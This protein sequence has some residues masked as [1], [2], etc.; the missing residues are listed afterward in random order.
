MAN[1]AESEY[2]DRRD[3]KLR[4]LL[5]LMDSPYDFFRLSQ[6]ETDALEE[7]LGDGFG[8]VVKGSQA[9]PLAR[10]IKSGLL[11]HPF[12]FRGAAEDD[13]EEEPEDA[14]WK[15]GL[16]GAPA[17]SE[18]FP[19]RFITRRLRLYFGNQLDRFCHKMISE[20]PGLA[21]WE[22][23]QL[24]DIALDR[25]YEKPWYEFHAI[26]SLDFIHQL[27]RRGVRGAKGATGLALL[28]SC[29]AGELGRLS[30]QYYWRFRYE[31]AAITGIGR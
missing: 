3:D 31:R 21:S 18:R 6:A 20:E 7:A 16:D 23:C 17:P 13:G 2:P 26:E 4:S 12:Y 10:G 30:E 24:E 19:L 5:P 15:E 11:H 29:F 27:L 8:D 9:L 1:T 14:F 25:L 22:R 28:V